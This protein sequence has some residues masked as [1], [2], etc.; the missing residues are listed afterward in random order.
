MSRKQS[1]TQVYDLA[2]AKRIVR[3]LLSH[4]DL[5]LFHHTA[6]AQEY[7]EVWCD[8]DRAGCRET[9]H[10]TSSWQVYLGDTLIIAN[11][12]TQP[13]I[14]LSSCEAEFVAMSHSMSDGKYVQELLR[15]MG[16]LTLGVRMHC[17]SSS[18]LQSASRHGM[19]KLRH[20][21]VRH[22]WIQEELESGRVEAVKEKGTENG[23]DIGTKL[24]DGP[25]FA[26]CRS[27]LG[28]RAL[29]AAVITQLHGC[30]Q[31]SDE[32]HSEQLSTP[33]II[34]VSTIL[35]V[36]FLVGA[37]ASTVCGRFANVTPSTAKTTQ[38]MA[39]G[40]SD[41]S[42]QVVVV[43]PPDAWVS[44]F[45][46]RWHLDRE[47]GGLGKARGVRRVSACMLCAGGKNQ[48]ERDREDG[49]VRRRRQG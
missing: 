5:G 24:L 42:S 29:S 27:Q 43:Q 10:S 39:P 36:G 25:A 6:A 40:H 31:A 23:A 34:L 47:C 12:K 15:E 14:A 7:V 30:A 16:C 48:G 21:A 13:R 20:V 26:V 45:G 32:D 35:M 19:G 1:A 41:A 2:A 49:V 33:T 37:G 18:A 17:D 11:C 3:Y 46:E 22:L 4:R 38:T 28:I 44:G 8:S 9:R